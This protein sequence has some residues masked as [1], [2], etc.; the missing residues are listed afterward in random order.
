M[1]K[2]S[3]RELFEK[4]WI[5]C[6]RERKP[7]KFDHNPDVLFVAIDPAGGGNMSDFA[8]CSLAYENARHVVITY[9]LLACFFLNE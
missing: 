2:S 4:N 3:R 9:V 8:V 1:V 5:K 6:L 7:Y